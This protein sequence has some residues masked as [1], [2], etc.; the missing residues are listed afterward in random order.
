MMK[1]PDQQPAESPPTA[2]ISRNAIESDHSDDDHTQLTKPAQKLFFSDD[3]DEKK[4]KPPPKRG[5]HG[6]QLS[7]TTAHTAT[8][9]T[10]SEGIS[11]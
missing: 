7:Q 4:P 5:N 3:F 8:G 1:A 2:A 10:S 9:K 6:K 11:S